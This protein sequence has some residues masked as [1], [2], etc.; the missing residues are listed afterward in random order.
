MTA[1]S[2]RVSS[3]GRVVIPAKFRRALGIKDGDE[4]VIILDEGAIRIS[5]RLQQLRR[6]QELVKRHVEPGRS[7]ADELIA[8]R[9]SEAD[10]E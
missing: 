9:R 4:V 8:E 7:L 1:V 10:S 3:N 6:A 5:T 2:T